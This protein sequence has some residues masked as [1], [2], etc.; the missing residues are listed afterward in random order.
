MQ[1][2][3]V[4]PLPLNLHVPVPDVDHRF[5]LLGGSGGPSFPRGLTPR[6]H[7]PPSRALD[8]GNAGTIIT[9]SGSKFPYDD[10]VI[11]VQTWCGTNCPPYSEHDPP[12]TLEDRV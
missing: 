6:S 11:V 2:H 5:Y 7:A 12:G 1:Q 10:A 9:L 4:G 3:Q 8:P